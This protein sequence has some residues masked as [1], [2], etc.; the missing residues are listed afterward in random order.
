L[1]RPSFFDELSGFE[2]PVTNIETNTNGVRIS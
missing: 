1:G 2:H